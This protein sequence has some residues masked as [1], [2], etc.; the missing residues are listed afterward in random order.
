MKTRWE[1]EKFANELHQ[2][3]VDTESDYLCEAAKI[4]K[5]AMEESERHC[6]A[7]RALVS[8]NI[9]MAN[10]RDAIVVRLEDIVRDKPGK[11]ASRIREVAR[12]YRP[13]D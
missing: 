12:K 10:E 3:G 2:R 4:I 13:K 5:A 7:N 11:L 6:L 1:M 9:G 8:A